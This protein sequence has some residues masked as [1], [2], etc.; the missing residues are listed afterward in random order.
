MRLFVLLLGLLVLVILGAGG[1]FAFADM[2][3]PQHKVEKVIP[4]DKFKA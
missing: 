2:P 1:Y 3:A 4:H